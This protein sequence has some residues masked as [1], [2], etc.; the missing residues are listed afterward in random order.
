MLSALARENR[1]R[2][3]GT[4]AILTR[5]VAAASKIDRRGMEQTVSLCIR[6]IRK[7]LHIVDDTLLEAFTVGQDVAI[8]PVNDTPERRVQVQ[9]V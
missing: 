8:P 5:T 3:R 1:G 7:V 2:R 6:R 4:L 9:N